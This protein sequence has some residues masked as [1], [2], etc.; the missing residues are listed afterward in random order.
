MAGLTSC[1][2]LPAFLSDIK[3]SQKQSKNQRKTKQKTN[4]TLEDT[5]KNPKPQKQIKKQP[6]NLPSSQIK[7]LLNRLA[8][9]LC[10]QAFFTL[11][12]WMVD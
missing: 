12:A 6:G 1:Y 4:Q 11:A 8:I 9:F 5:P 2:N 3:L 7:K 10:L